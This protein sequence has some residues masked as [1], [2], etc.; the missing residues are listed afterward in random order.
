MGEIENYVNK[1]NNSLWF[2]GSVSSMAA[3]LDKVDK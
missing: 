2:Y 3:D 1:A